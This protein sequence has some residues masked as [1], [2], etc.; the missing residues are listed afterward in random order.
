VGMPTSVLLKNVVVEAA[1]PKAGIGAFADA[2]DRRDSSSCRKGVV[3]AKRQTAP[4]RP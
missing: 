1:A 2:S 4:A 3:P